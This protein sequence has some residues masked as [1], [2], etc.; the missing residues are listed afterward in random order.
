LHVLSTTEIARLFA[1]EYCLDTDDRSM[2]EQ[3]LRAQE[4]SAA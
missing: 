1:S 2:L 3:W 4:A